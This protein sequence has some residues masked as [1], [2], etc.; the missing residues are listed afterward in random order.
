MTL[1][2]LSSHDVAMSVGTGLGVVRAGTDYDAYD[3]S[4]HG[5]YD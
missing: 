2:G 5:A 3:C 4:Y 1:G